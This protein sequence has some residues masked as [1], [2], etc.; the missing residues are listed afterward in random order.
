M[1]APPKGPASVCGYHGHVCRVPEFLA[2]VAQGYPD[3]LV[4]IRH[5]EY[6]CKMQLT[7]IHIRFSDF[8]SRMIPTA[9]GV[10]Y[11][12]GMR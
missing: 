2:E 4:M 1:I 6:H 10:L 5:F 9:V 7:S 3:P 8:D 12:H 11:T